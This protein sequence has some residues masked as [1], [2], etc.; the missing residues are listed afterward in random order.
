MNRPS[1]AHHYISTQHNHPAALGLVSGD[2]QHKQ[3]VLLLSSVSFLPSLLFSPVVVYVLDPGEQTLCGTTYADVRRSTPHS[4]L[5]IST[6]DSQNCEF[7]G[8][9][10]SF[11]PFLSSILDLS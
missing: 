4:E 10:P 2:L 6:T 11:S 5:I 7:W 3:K 8:L 1:L 9:F